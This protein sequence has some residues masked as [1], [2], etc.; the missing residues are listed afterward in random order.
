[1]PYRN[2]IK[3]GLSRRKLQNEPLDENW[4]MRSLVYWYIDSMRQKT[5]TAVQGQ[6]QN[7]AFHSHSA[8]SR[9]DGLPELN[10]KPRGGGEGA[11]N[12]LSFIA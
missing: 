7:T 11:L 8:L 12:I 4:M 3:S 5:R 10:E 1:M 9:S 2:K 6:A